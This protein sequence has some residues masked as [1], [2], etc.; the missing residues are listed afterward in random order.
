MSKIQQLNFAVRLLLSPVPALSRC[1]D[2]SGP[3]PR[4]RALVGMS[5]AASLPGLLTPKDLALLR[6]GFDVACS[7]TGGA[8]VAQ[9][10]ALD[11]LQL[12]DAGCLLAA[13]AR[14]DLA[15]WINVRRDRI[16][17]AGAQKRHNAGPKRRTV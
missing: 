10:L 15:G 13:M 16:P 6:F 4:G 3:T 17:S 14:N 1:W 2:D 5:G 9:L 7:G 12:W 11:E 8:T